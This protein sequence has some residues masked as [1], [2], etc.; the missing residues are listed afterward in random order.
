MS[1]L[2]GKNKSISIIENARE[3]LSHAVDHLVIDETNTEVAN[4]KRSVLDV[5]HVVELI[6]KEK[7]NQVHPA[8][9][10][11]KVDKYP[12][13]EAETINTVEAINRLD[14]ICQIK[15]SKESIDTI[16]ICRRLRNKIEHFQFEMN[17]KKTKVVLGRML[18]FILDFSRNH[19]SINFEEEFRHD[20]KWEL[21]LEMYEFWEEWR[22]VKE[23]ELNE[24][25]GP[26]AGCHVCGALT[27]DV[28]NSVCV[29]CGN[30]EMEW[31]CD[32]C[33]ELFPE[34]ELEEIEELD[35]DQDSQTGLLTTYFVCPNCIDRDEP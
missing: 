19:L 6:I 17:L 9:I 7:L 11:K 28:I 30:T 35:G 25:D 26:V 31:Q 22:I 4:L 18:S 27:F 33:G 1:A 16:K 5:S 15:L 32:I 23:R 10:W 34:S 14:R 3:S 13:L 20:E 2:V 24:S 21:L 12:S 8:F 29:L